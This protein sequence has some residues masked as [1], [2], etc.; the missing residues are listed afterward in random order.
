MHIHSLPAQS[1][2][3]AFFVL[4]LQVLLFS[5]GRGSIYSIRIHTFTETTSEYYTVIPIPYTNTPLNIY[6]Y[7]YR[8]AGVSSVQ[9]SPKKIGNVM[10]QVVLEA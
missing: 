5:E 3:V 7:I 1:E 2:C 9:A 4:K 8:Y 6:K 10:V